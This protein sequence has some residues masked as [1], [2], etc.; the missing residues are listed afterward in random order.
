M[1]SQFYSALFNWLRAFDLILVGAIAVNEA[2]AAVNPSDFVRTV[3]HPYYPLAPG[4]TYH[5]EGTLDATSV[6]IVTHETKVVQ[7]VVCTVVRERAISEGVVSEESLDW[8]AQ[9]K[10]GNVWFFGEDSRHF[11]ANGVLTNTQGSW[12]AGVNGAVAGMI[13]PALP[14]LGQ[15]YQQ[16]FAPGV[17]EDMATVLELTA[18]VQTPFGTF[19][20][21]MLTREFSRLSPEEIEQRYYA[22]GI[23]L[24]LAIQVSGESEQL[25]LGTITREP[26]SP[27]SFVEGVD[28]PYY[29]LIPG[30]TQLYEGSKQGFPVFQEISIADGAKVILGVKCTVV[31]E[32]VMVG[33]ILTDENIAW[34]AQDLQG[35][36]WNFGEL[37][38]Q[39]N[40]NGV[41]LSTDG[42]WEAG[43]FGAEPGIIMPARPKL[44]QTYLKERAPGVALDMATVTLVRAEVRLRLGIFSDCLVTRDFSP[45]HPGEVEENYY[46]PGVGLILSV[47]PEDPGGRLELASVHPIPRPRLRMLPVQGTNGVTLSLTG[48]PGQ[49]YSVETSTDLVSWKP[50]LTDTVGRHRVD[51]GL[52]NAISNARQFYRSVVPPGPFSR[53][54]TTH[55]LLQ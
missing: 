45:L 46:A 41:V 36:V 44:N 49:T 30:T 15:T 37:T 34:F 33:G 48:F 7:G 14:Q 47:A 32:R 19:A 5:F 38:K 51:Y 54:A 16:E 29:P 42:S 26:V 53:Q 1:T 50:F 35:A 10:E 55:E 6:R 24:V 43:K 52:T 20:H 23:G 11:D 12:E 4:T 21:C 18:G 13:M 9:D 17:A 22:P 40:A 39:L 8:F 25:E 28:H 31:H 27:S 3:D 2:R